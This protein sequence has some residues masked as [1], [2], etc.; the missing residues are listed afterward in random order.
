[1]RVVIIEDEELAAEKLA[2]MLHQYDP[3]IRVT[4]VLASVETAVAWLQNNPS[5]DLL[6]VDIQLS[7][8][9]CFGIFR[10]VPVRCPVI[11]TTAYDQYALRAFQVYS[12][13]YLLKP[14]GQDKLN[15]SLDKLRD[16]RQSF[17]GAP[18]EPGDP[19]AL[20]LDA[21]VQLI[22]RGNAGYKS[23]FMVRLGNRIK[24]VKTDEVA[25]FLTEQKL[26]LLVTKENQ[27]YP[28][29]YSL[30]E[31]TPMLDPAQF[32]RVNRQLIIHLDAAAEIHPYFK[33]RLKLIL[34]PPL[35][36]EVIVSSERTPAFKAWLEQ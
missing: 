25:Y 2:A 18:P 29:D 12:V 34:S 27:R 36:E 7:D 8:E 28:V 31:L 3:A 35:R 19:P 6:L 22:R 11:F 17:A 26:S 5:P 16:M 21:L 14:I 33:G 13:D 9:L 32:F 30:D 15:Q 4:A 1:M 24:A 10:Q 23:R 20:P